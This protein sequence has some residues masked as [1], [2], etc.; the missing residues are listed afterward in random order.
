MEIRTFA[1]PKTRLFA[2]FWGMYIEISY[3][4][5]L[6]SSAGRATDL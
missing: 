2:I 1:V 5:S 6:L 4:K 3:F